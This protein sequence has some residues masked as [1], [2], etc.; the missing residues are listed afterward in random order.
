MKT[1]NT[2]GDKTGSRFLTG[3]EIILTEKLAC[4]LGTQ[5]TVE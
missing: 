5:R 3:I 4:W 1:Q 2:I